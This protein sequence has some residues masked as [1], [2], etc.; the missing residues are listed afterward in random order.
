VLAW[1]CS[2]PTRPHRVGKENLY[3]VPRFPDF[4][5]DFPATAGP[6]WPC[7]SWPRWPCCDSLRA[8]RHDSGPWRGATAF[9]VRLF[10]SLLHAGLSRRSWCPQISPCAV[11]EGDLVDHA[12]RPLT[13][14]R[15]MP[16]CHHIKYQKATAGRPVLTTT[17]PARSMKHMLPSCQTSATPLRKSHAHP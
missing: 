3:G 15:Y 2:N 14:P 13:F 1:P 17:F 5:P 10:H 7:D 8:R 4:P 6:R 11:L 16:L 12:P 9:H